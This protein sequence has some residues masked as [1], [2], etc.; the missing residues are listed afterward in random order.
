[1]IGVG[2]SWRGTDRGIMSWGVDGW[3]G[4][5]GDEVWRIRDGK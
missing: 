4:E 2:L 5:G 1:M 3:S